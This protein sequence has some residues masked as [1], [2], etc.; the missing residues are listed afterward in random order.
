MK[1]KYTLAT[2]KAADPVALYKIAQDW[3][4]SLR[5]HFLFAAE[6]AG[7]LAALRTPHTSDESIRGSYS[8]KLPHQNSVKPTRY[9]WSSPAALQNRTYRTHDMIACV[10]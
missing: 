8:R 2:L 3:R 4:C 7:L 1:L 10:S 6:R 5:M 9:A